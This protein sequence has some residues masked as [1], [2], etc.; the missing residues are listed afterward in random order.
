MANGLTADTLRRFVRE[1]IDARQDETKASELARDYYDGEQWSRAEKGILST[2]NQPDTVFNRIQRKVDSVIGVEQRTRTDPKAYPRTP[3][4][5]K[6]GEV[7]TDV[8][9]YV[10]DNNSF[11]QIKSAVFENMLIEGRGAAEVVVEDEDVVIRHIPWDEYLPDPRSRRADYS[12][13]RFH[14]IVKWMDLDAAKR[15]APDYADKIDAAVKAGAKSFID[16]LEDKPDGTSWVDGKRK[17]VQVAQMYYRDDGWR[18]ALIIGGEKLED[19]ESAYVDDKGRTVCPILPQSAY[20]KRDLQRYGLVQSM[21]G[22]Q[23]EINHRRSKL[24]HWV[25]QRRLVVEEGATTD[26]DAMRDELARPDGVVVIPRGSKWDLLQAG[27]QGQGQATLLQQ[28]MEEIDLLGP[29]ASLQGKGTESQSGRAI[30]AQQQAGL[31]ELSPLFDRLNDWTIRV[32]RA[33]WHRVK[34]YWTAPRWVRVTDNEDAPKFVGVNQPVMDPQTGQVEQF[35]VGELDVDI[36]LSTGPDLTVLQ[37]EQFEKLAEFAP[38]LMQ[39]GIP[40]QVMGEILL[41]ASDFRNKDELLEAWEQGMVAA[42]QMSQMQAQLQQVMAQLEMA[43]KQADVQKTQAEV[44]ETQTDADL[45]RAR[46]MKEVRDASQPPDWVVVRSR[47]KPRP[48]TGFFNA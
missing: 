47:N 11:D 2:R 10:V 8:L 43:Q 22:A 20:V 46:T 13:A 34:Q 3:M 39:A 16:D 24:V 40:P 31:A 28:A 15:F 12:D 35:N 21:K 1:S 14:G 25:D 29:N 32:Y 23:D 44:V 18:Y 19:S 7:A 48:L 42:Q 27:E 37:G 38:M 30:I 26:P 5:E 45:N 41:K 36:V 4:D 33:I 6:S 17:R 9:R